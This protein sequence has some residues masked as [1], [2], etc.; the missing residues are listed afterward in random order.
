MI[1]I[2]QVPAVHHN[3]PGALFWRPIYTFLDT[4]MHACITAFLTYENGGLAAD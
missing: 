3:A 2:V 4:G 1:L